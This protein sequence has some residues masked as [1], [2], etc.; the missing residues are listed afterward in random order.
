MI[1]VRLLSPEPVGWLTH[2]Q[3]YSGLGADIVME[4]ISPT[5]RFCTLQAVRIKRTHNW[6]ADNCAGTIHLNAQTEKSVVG[7]AASGSTSLR[8]NRSLVLAK[9]LVKRNGQPVFL[10][11]PDYIFLMRADSERDAGIAL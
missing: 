6:F 7:A 1:I 3:L 10:K 4:S 5:T 8:I 11:K 9:A 2:H